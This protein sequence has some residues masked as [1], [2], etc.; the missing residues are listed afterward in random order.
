MVPLSSPVL[1]LQHVII[2]R[3]QLPD[4]NVQIGNV[5]VVISG[6]TDGSIAFWDLTESVEAFMRR[7]S[8]IH[9]E[10]FMDCQKRPRTGRGSQ[11]GRW[12]RSL[13]KIAC[14]EQPINDPVTAKAIK[15][16]NRK[17]TGGVACGSSSSMLDA[18][19]ELDSNAANSS[20]EIIEVNPF[21][22]LN[23]VHQSGVNCLHVC[24]TK[25]GQS[26][27]GRFLYQ[28]VSGGDDQALHLLKFEVLVQPPVQVPDVPNSDIR[29]SILVEEFLLDEQNQKTKCTIEFISQEKIASAHNS[30]V[31]G[32]WTD[33]T[34]VFSTGLDQRVRCWISKDRGTPTE[35]A[36]FIISVPEPE[37][38][39]ARSICW[40]QYQIAVAGRGMQMIE[41]HVPSSEIR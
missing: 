32:V 38:L 29:N 24:E 9:L 17:L 1:S 40:D 7:L 23:G 5:Y 28:L 34:W 21:H 13:S 16:L 30:A 41:F 39:D 2:G 22:V 8:N 20:F 6:A 33:G 19:P 11:G 18:S 36:H 12:W 31:K 37:A 3:C 35:L 15:E 27:D 10:K 14:K 4:E 25:H 26:S